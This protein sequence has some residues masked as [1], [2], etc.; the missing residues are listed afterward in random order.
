MHAK[1]R[2]ESINRT[3]LCPG[4]PT[5][6]SQI[7][8]VNVVIAIG[9]EE[10]YCGKPIQNF[11]PSFRTRKALKDLLEHEARCNNR[12]ARFNRSDQRLHFRH[13]SRR[14]APERKRPNACVNEQA[15]SRRRSAL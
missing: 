3:D 11:R 9:D 1:L 6:I 12:L 13:R 15:Q 5:P 7:S 14:I 8:S 10:R 4:S 2:H